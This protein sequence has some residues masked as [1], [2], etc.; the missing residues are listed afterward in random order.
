[1]DKRLSYK[2]S[3][4]QATLCIML[5]FGH[6]LNIADSNVKNCGLIGLILWYGLYCFNTICGMAVP[7]F[8]VISGYLY[9]YKYSESYDIYIYF[10]QL[11]TRIKSIIVP[12]FVW[13]SVAALVFRLVEKQEYSGNIIMNIL[14]SADN[15][16]LWYLRNL[17][18][19]VLISPLLYMIIKRKYEGILIGSILLINIVFQNQL[20]YNSVLY[21]IIYYSIGAIMA[22]KY[23]KLAL[24]KYKNSILILFSILSVMVFVMA[25]KTPV[26]TVNCGRFFVNIVWVVTLF[27]MA[28]K[29]ICK[30]KKRIMNMFIVYCGHT[31]L[32]NLW[33]RIQNHVYI[34]NEIFSVLTQSV[35][36]PI[37]I[38]VLLIVF[39]RIMRQYIPKVYEFIGGR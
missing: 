33:D 25:T 26:L 24:K 14:L 12:Y 15:G 11:K 22:L 20:T 31:I 38:I 8:F 39:T 16:P 32:I 6:S 4:I 36:I 35:V 9:F 23:Q 7:C 3:A 1:M 30:P 5:V 29:F 27:L 18:F 19:Y 2:I 21:C 28:D 34:Q 37:V 10:R 17:I 13:S